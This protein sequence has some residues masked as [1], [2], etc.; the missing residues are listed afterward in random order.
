MFPR[1]PTIRRKCFQSH[2]VRSQT[3]LEDK[4]ERLLDALES[5]GYE[6]TFIRRMRN[7]YAKILQHDIAGKITGYSDL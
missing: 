1:I 5:Q 4:A 6:H 7:T 2:R 3:P